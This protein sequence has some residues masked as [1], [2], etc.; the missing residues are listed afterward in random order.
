MKYFLM[1][2]I[3]LS[4]CQAISEDGGTEKGS[5]SFL[6]RLFGASQGNDKKQIKGLQI[7][8]DTSLENYA[9]LTAQFDSY[10]E[11]TAFEISSLKDNIKVNLEKINDIE[12]RLEG[13]IKESK[14]TA[15]RQAKNLKKQQ[16]I[17]KDLLAYKTSSE[18]KIE[19]LQKALNKNI[20]LDATKILIEEKVG[21]VAVVAKEAKEGFSILSKKHSEQVLYWVLAVLAVA[22][23]STVL[24][25]LMRKK[26]ISN[27]ESVSK[28]LRETS[29]SL[30]EEQVSLDNKL[31][32]IIESQLSIIKNS[33][34]N[35]E[36]D[37][38]LAL[39]VAD[40]IVRIRK[41]TS[42]MDKSTKGL[43]QLLASVTRIQDNFSANGYE[44]V[45]MQGQPYDE[46]M[47]ATVNFV[48][49]EELEP[50]QSLISKIIKPQVNY[51]GLMIQT[52]QIEV[53]IGE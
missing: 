34:T 5:P 31:T 21:V 24:F 46:R 19:D 50:G 51:Q 47:K 22:I 49:D 1:V 11:S 16:L 7:K 20:N 52:A 53:S 45:E 26:I 13:S 18:V 48:V 42:R 29:D 9:G 25:V 23:F 33:D 30:K 32:G 36:E 39:K 12:R 10:K 17:R 15:N 41:N 40:E 38:S 14:I 4:A 27:E 8:L 44:I 43:K 35:K 2:C 28:R 3:A 37:H 6:E